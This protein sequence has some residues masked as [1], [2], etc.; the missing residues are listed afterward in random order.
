MGNIDIA[1]INNIKVDSG[2]MRNYGFIEGG[3]LTTQCNKTGSYRIFNSEI[4]YPP[5][6]KT[7]ANGGSDYYVYSYVAEDDRWIR[8]ECR[9]VR[10]SNVWERMCISGTWGDWQLLPNNDQIKAK[11]DLKVDKDG[12]KQL[13]DENFTKTEKDKLANMNSHFRGSFA[14]SADLSTIAN[15]VKGDYAVVGS[16]TDITIWV[17][18]TAWKNTNGKMF[19]DMMKSIYSPWIEGDLADRRNHHHTQKMDTI[20]GLQ[21]ALDSKVGKETVVNR[22]DSESETDVLSAWQGN[23]LATRIANIIG[24]KIPSDY[25]SYFGETGGYVKLSSGLIVQFGQVKTTSST[26]TQDFMF[27]I[28]FPNKAYVVLAS[29]D[30]ASSAGSG[31]DGVYTKLVDNTKASITHDYKNTSVGSLNH[32]VIALGH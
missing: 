24:G 8:L 22:L 27:P 5:D 7:V 17:Y 19:G 31:V 28:P 4:G 3:N 32:Y 11:M 25:G 26:A 6:A 2:F 13:S 15:P 9:N 29:C 30:G 1:S 10:N 18:D 16:G 14:T 21:E 12:T 23:V 20:A